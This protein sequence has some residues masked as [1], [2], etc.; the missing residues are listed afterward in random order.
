MKCP[1]ARK[2]CSCLRTAGTGSQLPRR[3]H[4]VVVKATQAPEQT[5]LGTPG[6]YARQLTAE[7]IADEKK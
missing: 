2:P 6:S 7:I 3:N 5:E 4:R 1:L